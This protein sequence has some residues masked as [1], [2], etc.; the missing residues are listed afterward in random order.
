LWIIGFYH[1]APYGEKGGLFEDMGDALN[2][3]ILSSPHLSAPAP[4]RESC[5]FFLS[6]KHLTIRKETGW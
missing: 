3:N 4:L 6:K 5:I 1:L 2:P